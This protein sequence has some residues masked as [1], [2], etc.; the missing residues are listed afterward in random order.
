[1]KPGGGYHVDRETGR[2]KPVD[3]SAISD[4]ARNAAVNAY[5]TA[6]EKALAR[7]GTEMA[8]ADLVRKEGKDEDAENFE[9]VAQACKDLAS[10]FTM[11]ANETAVT[12]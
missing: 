9:K 11:L 7:A 1:M 3:P 8:C 5:R 4:E 2:V 10:V 12:K 6:A